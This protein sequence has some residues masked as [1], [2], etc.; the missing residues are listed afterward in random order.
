MRCPSDTLAVLTD[1]GQSARIVSIELR[2]MPDEPFDVCGCHFRERRDH[3][4]ITQASASLD[5]VRCVQAGLSSSPTAAAMPPCAHGDDRKELLPEVL[6][7][8][9]EDNSAGRLH[10]AKGRPHQHQ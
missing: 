2:P 1:R 3:A 9:T 5:R 7:T 8:T 6:S 10:A 4:T